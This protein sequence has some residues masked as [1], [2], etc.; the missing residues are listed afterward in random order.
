MSEQNTNEQLI[1]YLQQF[2]T[3]EKQEKIAQI[4]AGRTRHLTIVLEELYQ[5]HNASAALRSAE[6]FGIQDVHIIDTNRSFAL[7]PSIAKGAAQWLDV[8]K[9]PSTL[10]CFNTLKAAGY[11]IVGTSLH[12]TAST[13][14]ELP[15][16]SKIA[17]VFGTEQ[18]GLSDDALKYADA[19]ITVPMVGFTQSLN[20]SVAVGICLYDLTARLRTTSIAWQL[21][22]T[23]QQELTLAWLRKSLIHHAKLERH[24][25]KQE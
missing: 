8:H 13:I 4:I 2:V 20:V 9:H 22:I 16:D 19:F 25:F 11:T 6:C 3:I 5:S 10:I 12:P 23:E 7:S 14:H 15:L 24:F 21:S 17:L 1:A 18:H